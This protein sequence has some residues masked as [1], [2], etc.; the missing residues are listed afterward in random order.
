MKMG[1]AEMPLLF[2][3]KYLDVLRLTIVL[4]FKNKN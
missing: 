1:G 2:S 3:V 4:N